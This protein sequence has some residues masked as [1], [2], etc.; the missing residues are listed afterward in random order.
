MMNFKATALNREKQTHLQAAKAEKS[1]T[2]EICDTNPF[3]DK[4]KDNILAKHL[5]FHSQ[6][7]SELI[8]GVSR[9]SLAFF[10]L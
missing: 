7:L 5:Q 2:F 8:C 9:K 4:V 6:V 10:G 1:S 3:G